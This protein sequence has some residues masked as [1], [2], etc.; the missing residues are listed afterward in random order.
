MFE[1]VQQVLLVVNRKLTQLISND[2]VSTY[3]QERVHSNARALN[4]NKISHE[5]SLNSSIKWYDQ[6]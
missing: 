5:V 6:H 1:N 2:E 3:F 4:Q